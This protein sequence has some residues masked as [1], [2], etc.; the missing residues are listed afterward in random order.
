M[1]LL[2][3]AIFFTNIA[4]ILKLVLSSCRVV[5]NSEGN[6]IEEE[7]S[8]ESE[9]NEEDDELLRAY[10]LNNKKRKRAERPNVSSRPTTPTIPEEDHDKETNF[11]ETF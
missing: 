9:N 8:S 5:E 2:A 1:F 10:I 11:Y 6:H 7:D 4:L 3:Y